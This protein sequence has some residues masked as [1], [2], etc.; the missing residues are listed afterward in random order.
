MGKLRKKA[1]EKKRLISL[2]REKRKAEKRLD[3]RSE[4]EKKIN[5]WHQE[6]KSE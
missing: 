3:R 2:R 5:Q 4:R 1:K 6:L